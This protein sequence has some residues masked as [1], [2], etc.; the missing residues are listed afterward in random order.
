MTSSRTLHEH[1]SDTLE[2][3]IFVR[4]NSLFACLVQSELK[5]FF[6]VIVIIV[7]IVMIVVQFRLQIS[8]KSFE[9]YFVQ[10]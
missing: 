9:Q 3:N 1:G 7:M 4:L 10:R 6:S 5:V 8:V 2:L